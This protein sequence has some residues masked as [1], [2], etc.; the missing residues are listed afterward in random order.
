MKQES[1]KSNN[2][3][4]ILLLRDGYVPQKFTEKRY[5][6]PIKAKS[7]IVQNL[8]FRRKYIVISVFLP[9]LSTKIN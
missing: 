4:L 8:N 6:I 5:D 1:Y 3:H 7:S 9:C 2:I